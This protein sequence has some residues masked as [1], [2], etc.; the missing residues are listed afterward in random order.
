MEFE[1]SQLNEIKRGA[2]KA[3]YNKEEIY[4]I[5]DSTEVC[6]I[7]F[8][9][10]GVAM[11]QPINF[12]RYE[13]Y[14]FIH[15]SHLNRMT[16]AIINSRMVSLNIML[17]DGLK[18]TRSAFHHSVNYRSVS[19]FGEAK[20]LTDNE[21]KLLGLKTIINHFIPTRWEYCRKPNTKEIDATRVI[22]IK[23]ITASAKI[24]NSP[25]NDNK[26]DLGLE[27]WAGT[28]PVNINYGTPIP[29]QYTTED[30]PIPDHVQ[31]FLNS[32]NLD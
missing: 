30:M 14:I 25:P 21:E 17:L 28:I 22:K 8:N 29:D 16:D 5:I 27:Y 24:A 19:V 11:V 26:S 15:G 12:G 18:L 1:K 31:K 6:H 4:A 3:S 23:I 2:K 13:D 20:E 7:A 10:E 32:R 9:F